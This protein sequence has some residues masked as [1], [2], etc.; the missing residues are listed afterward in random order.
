MRRIEKH[1]T[2]AI[3]TEFFASIRPVRAIRV[4]T[5]SNFRL[6]RGVECVIFSFACS[7]GIPGFRAHPTNGTIEKTIKTN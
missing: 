4:S 1:Y 2:N 7:V 3:G 6:S 5:C